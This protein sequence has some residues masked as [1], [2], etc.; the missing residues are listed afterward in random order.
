MFEQLESVG[1]LLQNPYDFTHLALG[2]LIHYLEKQ[3]IQFFWQYFTFSFFDGFSE[4]CNKSVNNNND[5][6]DYNS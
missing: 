1:N 4:N 5:D 3:K 2:M 6:N